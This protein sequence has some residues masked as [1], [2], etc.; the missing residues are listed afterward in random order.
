MF[1]QI[2]DVAEDIWVQSAI[3][4]LEETYFSFRSLDEMSN[5]CA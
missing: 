5:K 4:G 3:S 1:L 2:T